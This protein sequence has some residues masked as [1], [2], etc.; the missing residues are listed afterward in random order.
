MASAGRP[1]REKLDDAGDAVDAEARA[2]GRI[3]RVGKPVV[4]VTSRPEKAEEA[5]RLGI[6]VERIDLDLSEPQALDPGEIVDAKARAAFARLDRPVLVEDS[7]LQIAA[8]N[9][10]PGRS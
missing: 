3:P 6:A 1:R 9:G 10:F 4:L 2:H 7:G 5:R 8:W